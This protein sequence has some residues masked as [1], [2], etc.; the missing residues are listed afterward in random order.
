M[1][2]IFLVPQF[3][4][5]ASINVYSLSWS[6]YYF[7]TSRKSN[8]AIFPKFILHSPTS[9]KFPRYMRVR[10]QFEKKLQYLKIREYFTD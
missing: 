2:Q 7:A 6:P 8:C 5:H 9:A 10:V 4:L 1:Y 3:V